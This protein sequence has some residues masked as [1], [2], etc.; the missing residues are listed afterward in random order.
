MK[1]WEEEKKMDE[2]DIELNTRNIILAFL[3]EHK[4]NQTIVV[5]P[6]KTLSTIVENL[7]NDPFEEKFK[8]LKKSNKKIQE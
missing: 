6:L 8:A 4:F 2:D 1:E 5:P 7:V 3:K